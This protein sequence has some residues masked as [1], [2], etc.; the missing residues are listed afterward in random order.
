MRPFIPVLALALG[1]IPAGAA[2]TITTTAYCS[3]AA[4][5]G[6]S[7][8]TSCAASVAFGE[9]SVR[10]RA[11]VSA[12]YGSASGFA[13]VAALWGTSAAGGASFLAEFTD[14]VTVTVLGDEPI[15][16]VFQAPLV[17]GVAIT[18]FGQI[19][20]FDIG[21]KRAT[22]G[23][24]SFLSVSTPSAGFSAFASIT[25]TWQEGPEAYAEDRIVPE[26]PSGRIELFSGQELTIHGRFG[27]SVDA[28][29]SANAS[30]GASGDF[31]ALG[32][33][34]AAGA[35]VAMDASMPV[36]G[37]YW[38]G[39]TFETADGTPVA[40]ELVMLQSAS[41]TDWTLAAQPV[42]EPATW[43]LWALGLGLVGAR[44]RRTHASA[45]TA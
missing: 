36:A 33:R 35:V 6:E 40:A 9:Q 18:S 38:R 29:G 4:G 3:P 17:T 13:S 28:L 20:E 30:I 41:G 25:Q 10:T 39:I 21:L 32:S 16:A 5:G 12:G 31:A 23:S 22:V 42:P 14:R 44:R 45:E 34:R 11:R 27:A 43:A 8:D 19:D 37:M 15:Y 1:A 24:S 26:A 7:G 2:A